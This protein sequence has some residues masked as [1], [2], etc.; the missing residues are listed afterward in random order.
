[1]GSRPHVAMLLMVSCR[2]WEDYDA[3][4]VDTALDPTGRCDHL[5]EELEATC[6]GL[7]RAACVRACSAVSDLDLAALDECMH[8]AG[9]CDGD[10]AC[11]AAVGAG[12]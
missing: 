7:D 5:W 8:D 12:C 10:L 4:P 3:L 9:T 2:L 6:E 1:M 11:L